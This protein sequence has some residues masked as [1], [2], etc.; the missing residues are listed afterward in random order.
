MTSKYSDLINPIINTLNIDDTKKNIIKGRFL[1][2]VNLY[3]TKI[4]S[5]KKWYDFFHKLNLKVFYLLKSTILSCTFKKTI[6]DCQN[7]F[8]V[9]FSYCRKNI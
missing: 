3:D 4:V 6:C 9:L 2:E 5:V 7:S 1:N 8:L